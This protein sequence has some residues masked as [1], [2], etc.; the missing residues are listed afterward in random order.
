MKFSS[1]FV[2]VLMLTSGMA[3]AEDQDIIFKDDFN[4]KLG[5]GWS[6]VREDAKGWRIAGEA[7]EIRIQPGNMW[8]GA[9]NAKNVFVHPAPD[10]AKQPV[11]VSV[12]VSNRPTSQYEQVDLVWY[13]DDSNMIKIGLEQVDKVLCLV[14]GREENDRPRTI[15]KNPVESFS[16]DLRFLV[17][18]DKLKGQYRPSGDNPWKDAGECTLP[19]KGEPKVSLQVYQGPASEEHWGVFKAFRI[20]KLR[21]QASP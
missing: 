9:N 18:G 10:P 1:V 13:Y 21:G 3:V 5:D 6:W 16:L 20:A 19:V 11:E 7:L 2:A 17:S 8:G 4:G 15:A 12:T 14:M